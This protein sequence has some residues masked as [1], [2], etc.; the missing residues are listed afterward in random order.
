MHPNPRNNHNSM[1]IFV[2]LVAIMS[3]AWLVMLFPWVSLVI[4]IYMAAAY[5]NDN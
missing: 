1:K 4:V 3:V 5:L 2:A